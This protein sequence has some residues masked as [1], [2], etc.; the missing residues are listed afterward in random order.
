M[1][2]IRSRIIAASLICLFAG[3]AVSCQSTKPENQG[4]TV[5]TKEV[6]DSNENNNNNDSN[7]NSDDKSSNNSVTEAP[8]PEKDND[9]SKITVIEVTDAEN[10]P[11]TNSDKSKVT[12][13]AV[14][15]D[16]GNVITDDKGENVKPNITVTTKAD[17]IVATDKTEKTENNNNNNNNNNGNNNSENKSDTIHLAEGPTLTLPDGL[18]AKPGETVKFKIPVTGNTGYHGLIAWLCLDNKYFE[19]VSYEGGDPE[20]PNYTFSPQ[21]NNTTFTEIEDDD[22]TGISTIYSMYF[23]ASL[24]Q[25]TGDTTFAT[26]TIKVKDGTPA[27][28]YPLEFGKDPKPNNAMC[29]TIKEID[30]KKKVASL[31]PTYKN[32]SIIVK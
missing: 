7:N 26:I 11:V 20:D 24:D 17:R 22:N 18:E 8:V 30:G 5:V 21:R 9:G 23:D 13:L 6:T 25:I 15:D 10:K 29:N 1:K 31:T 14:V 19:F 12:E 32:G 28:E 2:E 4:T 16:K 3:S 27:G